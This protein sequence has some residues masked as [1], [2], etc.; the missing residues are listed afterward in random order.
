MAAGAGKGSEARGTSVHAA[1]TCGG[2]SSVGEAFL[3][4][5]VSTTF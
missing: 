2:F 5:E 1:L 3:V 4:S